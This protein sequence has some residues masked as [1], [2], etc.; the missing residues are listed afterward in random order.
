MASYQST[1]PTALADELVCVID[2]GA[3]AENNVTGSTSGKI[4]I[5]EAD[6]TKNPDFGVY[7]WVVDATSTTVG[8]TAGDIK[9]FVPRGTKS[10]FVWADGHAYSAGVSLWVTTDSSTTTTNGPTG[11]VSI[12]MVV[13]A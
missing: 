6:N 5:I 4:Y 8:S 12:K 13:T 10:E 9:V 3:A 1:S 7:V 2:V 11:N